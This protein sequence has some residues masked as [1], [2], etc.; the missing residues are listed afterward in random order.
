[1]SWTSDGH[2]NM[3]SLYASDHG[4]LASK[5]SEISPKYTTL[6]S[7]DMEHYIDHPYSSWLHFLTE[8]NVL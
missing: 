1:M 3:D 5:N 4:Y 6:T 7:D 8:D 2:E